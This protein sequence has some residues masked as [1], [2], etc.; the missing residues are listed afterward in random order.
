M[1][2]ELHPDN[3]LTPLPKQNIDTGMGL[4][5]TARILQNVASVYDTDGYQQIMGWIAETSGVAYGDS[6]DATKAHRVL[7]DHGRG[8]TFLVG[9]GDHAVE[10]GPRLRAA[11]GRSAARSSTGCGSGWRRPSSPI[12]R[13]R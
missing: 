8:M 13:R 7:A 9:R 4:E 12:C 3:T 10:R 6:V 1:A 5:R 2:Y 11:P